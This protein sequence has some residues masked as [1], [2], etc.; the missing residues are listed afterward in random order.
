ML[1]LYA[2]YIQKNVFVYSGLSFGAAIY[3]DD[4]RMRSSVSRF[5]VEFFRSFFSVNPGSE[6]SLRNY[7]FRFQYYAKRSSVH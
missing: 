3:F 5:V 7:V 4:K 2:L 1:F 6:K